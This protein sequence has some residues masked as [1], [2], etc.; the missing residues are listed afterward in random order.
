MVTESI[1]K[2]SF[3]LPSL[4][5]YSVTIYPSRAAVVRNISNVKILPGKN[6]ITLD[7]LT[8][9]VEERTIK[10]ETRNTAGVVTDVEVELVQS[11]QPRTCV[12]FSDSDEYSFTDDETGGEGL[13]LDPSTEGGMKTATPSTD[14]QGPQ[15]TGTA[16][17][18]EK[19]EATD[20]LTAGAG[21]R[22]AD[23][24]ISKPGRAAP[25]PR[26]A[27]ERQR[28]PS[29][30]GKQG[31]PKDVY[32]VRITVDLK[33]P[34]TETMSVAD[35]DPAGRPE[36]AKSA[37]A[38]AGKGRRPSLRVSYVTR[39]AF[40]TP[41]YGIRL[42]TLMNTGVLTYRA[43]IFNRTG[44]TWGKARVTLST[45]QARFSG[46]E[47]RAPSMDAW[48]ISLRPKA[49]GDD[50]DGGL[51]SAKEIKLQEDQ[52][53]KRLIG[54]R[55]KQGKGQEPDDRPGSD[56]EGSATTTLTAPPNS[57]GI[58]M[59]TAE[60]VSLTTTY[61]LPRACDVI[62]EQQVSRYIIAEHEL[63]EITFS[64]LCVPKL[65][66]S[67]FLKARIPNPSPTMLPSGP[68]GLSLDGAFLGTVRIPL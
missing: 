1:H 57:L 4:P 53:L 5:T 68:A 30:L 62:S 43:Y 58:P 15:R 7:N 14:K 19:I 23:A 22:A 39:G 42:D 52:K 13:S 9:N 21:A 28:K 66:P 61:H 11:V 24:A 67:V 46:L 34:S 37:K 6:E 51:Y 45:G 54:R 41:E 31:M 40:W 60:F 10:V 55:D 35:I 27:P 17:A 18:P 47:D 56:D 48:K 3:S 26:A 63:T 2:Q 49:C 16:G 29:R 38:P 36:P 64:H 32:R 50:S 12:I 25:E 8:P 44:E 33:P 20:L 59:P 65:C